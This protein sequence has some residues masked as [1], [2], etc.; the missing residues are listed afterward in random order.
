MAMR[1]GGL[2]GS[3]VSTAMA[4]ATGASTT[5]TAT[6]ITKNTDSADSVGVTES[7][8]TDLGEA[9]GQSTNQSTRY[10]Y[11]TQFRKKVSIRGV[12]IFGSTKTS[13]FSSKA[14]AGFLSAILEGVMRPTHLVCHACWYPCFSAAPDATREVRFDGRALCQFK[15]PLKGLRPR[16]GTCKRIGNKNTVSPN[17]GN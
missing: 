14:Q 16:K 2:E 7:I 6:D 9:T 8:T 3:G 12:P 17:K 13:A 1:V 4:T 15:K 11:L 5:T 10:T